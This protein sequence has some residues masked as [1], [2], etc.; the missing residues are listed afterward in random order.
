M[1]ARTDA[2]RQEAVAARNA[3]DVEVVRLQVA[4]RD[5]VDVRAQVKRH[6]GKAAG[7][8]AGAAFMAVGGPKRVFRAVKRR[9]RGEPEPLPESLLP[10]E[11]EKAVSAL[12]P[13]GAKVRGAIERSFRH[14]LDATSK[15]R[16]AEARDRSLVRMARKVVVPVA[17][18]AARQ[19][20]SR[21]MA[22]QDRK[23]GPGNDAAASP[24]PA[25][26]PFSGIARK[27]GQRG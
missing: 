5:A 19:A 11:I 26:G 14:Y 27:R 13:D 2:A 15:D 7:A 1:G 4:A 10:G 25:K 16:K 17:T 6:P 20:I 3:L 9:V 21:A 18:M 23:G 22:A 8:A 12:G 24:S